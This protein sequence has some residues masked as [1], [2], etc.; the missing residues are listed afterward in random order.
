MY[1]LVNRAIEELVISLKG[2]A[3]WRGVCAH[4]GLAS[5]G[6]VSMQSYDDDI[7]YRL[8]ESVSQKLGLPSEQVLEAFGEYWITYTAKEGYG[9]MLN[10]GGHSMRE[11]LGNLNDMHGRVGLIFPQLR[12]PL[13]R[14][15]P[16]SDDEYLLHY[17]S[18]R[19]GL[20]PMVIGLVR[21]LAA[22]FDQK[23]EIA[24]QQ[25]RATAQDEDIFLVRE[26]SATV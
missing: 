18:T 13:F 20:T 21:G 23:V 6:F 22:R 26:V 14:V 9:N 7:T 19:A 2:E 3:G 16:V 10:A 15:T 5:D 8:V 11:F 1:G 4:A 24:L 25:T 17:A 12:M